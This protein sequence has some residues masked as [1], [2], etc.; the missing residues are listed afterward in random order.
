[1]LNIVMTTSLAIIIIVIAACGI[2]TLLY[3]QNRKR[4]SFLL[5]VTMVLIYLLGHLLT[6]TSTGADEAFTAVKVVYLGGLFAT[7]FSFLFIADY[8]EIEI[9]LSVKIPLYIFPLI[10]VVLFWTTQSHHLIYTSY[11]F[12]VNGTHILRFEHGPLYILTYIFIAMSCVASDALVIYRLFD[13]RGKY[14]TQM[15]VLLCS[16]I[17]LILATVISFINIY[18]I[19]GGYHFYLP[20]ALAFSVIIIAVGIMRFDMFEIIPRATVVARDSI[21][22]SIREAFVLVDVEMNYLMSNSSAQKIF[23]GLADTHKGSAVMKVTDWPKELAVLTP[24]ME[25]NAISFS[26]TGNETRHYIANINRISGSIGW[27]ILIQ[28]ITDNF[29]LMKQLEEAAHTDALTGLF[30]RRFFMILANQHYEQEL[31]SKRPYCIMLIDLDFFKNINDTHGHLA[32]DEM[33]RETA[34]HIKSNIRPYDLLARYGGEE[35]I[36]LVSS[37]DVRESFKLAERIRVSIENMTCIHNQEKMKITCSIGLYPY[38][39][40]SLTD[41]LKNADAAMYSA[42]QK[43]RNR[44]EII[45]DRE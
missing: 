40:D 12:N 13:W 29:V 25:N 5:C 10:M 19:P 42:K 18:F 3:C 15:M 14:R 9:P 6:L 39:G 23:R 35:F 44:V 20:V 45:A 31:R 36:I 34:Q 1:M 28:D 17:P 41:M 16:T 2:H 43:G 8:C 27:I 22:N 4:E 7:S 26:L 38:S 30:N 37:A 32:G 21:L 33:L 24:D 11:S